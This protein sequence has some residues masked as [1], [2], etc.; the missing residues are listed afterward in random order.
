MPRSARHLSTTNRGL[1]PG[2]PALTGTGLPPASLIQLPRRN[3]RQGYRSGA[4]L[5]GPTL[6]RCP[7]ASGVT[8]R[9]FRW[10]W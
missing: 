7:I 5:S 6:G 8:S 10:A 1:L 9:S 2:A 4:T 3:M